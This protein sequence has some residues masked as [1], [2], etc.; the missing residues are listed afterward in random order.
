MPLGQLLDQIRDYYV[1]CFVNAINEHAADVNV[2]LAHESAFCNADGEL[3]TEGQL[4]LPA[5]GDIF[6]IRDG[7]VSDSLQIDTK[8]ML[9]FEPIAFAWPDSKIEVELRPF[10]WNW[11]QIR[12]FGLQASA[13]WTP[14]RDWFLQWFKEDDPTDQ[15][16]LEAVH[17]LSA[18]ETREDCSQVSVDLG[19]APVESF[20]ELLDA[21]GRLGGQRV[22]IGQFK[23]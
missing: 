19:T 4:A 17:F 14:I 8:E 15:E 1:N 7:I 16:L 2:A 18:P 23:D 5:R 10:Q 3:V 21:I 6:I 11:M 22:Q 12:I 13:D 20:E 9:S